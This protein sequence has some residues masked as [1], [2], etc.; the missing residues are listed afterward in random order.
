MRNGVM[1]RRDREL[2]A[3]PSHILSE[4]RSA[5]PVRCGCAA[6]WRLQRRGFIQLVPLLLVAPARTSRAADTVDASPLGIGQPVRPA[7]PAPSYV[8]T[9]RRKRDETLSSLRALSDSGDFKGL[10]DSL[11][12]SPFDDVRQ[13][14]FYLP[15][16][17]VAQDEAAGTRLETEWQK[18]RVQWMNLDATALAA[19]RFEKEDSDVSQAIDGFAQALDAYEAAIPESLK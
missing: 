13:A 11:V 17:V 18:V 5:A 19:A 12:L 16:A 15:W 10:S 14:C 4:M 1:L 8:A 3:K 6:Q 9:L 7:L 2:I